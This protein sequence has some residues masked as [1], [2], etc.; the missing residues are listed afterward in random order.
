MSNT[1]HVCVCMEVSTA[2]TR[3]QPEYSDR[4]DVLSCFG[5]E[6]QLIHGMN[7]V[8]THETQALK[9]CVT[10]GQMGQRIETDHP[11]SSFCKESPF[12][13]KKKKSSTFVILKTP[14]LTGYRYPN[15][16][17]FFSKSINVPQRLPLPG[18]PQTNHVCSSLQPLIWSISIVPGLL[19]ENHGY[20]KNGLPKQQLTPPVGSYARNLERP[21]QIGLPRKS[22]IN[23]LPHT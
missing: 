17:K 4:K 12:L 1:Q 6:E 9:P 16:A 8:S 19:S 3:M 18:N 23:Y 11:V 21:F 10:T 20:Q 5:V 22:R 13:G 7:A 14:K 15:T 2:E